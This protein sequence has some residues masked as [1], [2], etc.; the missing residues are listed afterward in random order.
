MIDRALLPGPRLPRRLQSLALAFAPLRFTEACH[1]RYGDVVAFRTVS[2]PRFVMVFEPG[3]VKQ[4]FGDSPERLGT[5]EARAKLAP[6]VGE[7][8][9]LMLDGA[10]HV[11]RRRLVLPPFHGQLMRAHL[12]DIQD[13]TDQAVDSWPTGQ[14]FPL[15]PSMQA[16]SLDV[17][18]RLVFG[19]DQE[20]GREELTQGIRAVLEPSRPRRL[21]MRGS[22]SSPAHPREVDELIYQEISR[23]RAA[24]DL[25]EREDVLS[26]LLLARDEDGRALTNAELRDEL[27]GLLFAGNETT[28][29]AL[30]WAFELLLRHPAVLARLEAELGN[31]EDYLNAVVKETLRL[32]PPR[33]L[34]GKGG[35]WAAIRAWGTSNPAWDGDKGVRGRRP[36]PRG[37]VP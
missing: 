13:A 7:R 25:E 11:R 2:N 6:V 14:P 9:V 35:S 37:P 27:V 5:G 20:R 32:R 22:V 24:L 17:L 21:R 16:L 1:R 18:M 33:G 4:M 36:S 12:A 3:L 31:G 19:R 28:P 29:T 15:V 23:R 26:L 34:R 8:S 30:A 10:E